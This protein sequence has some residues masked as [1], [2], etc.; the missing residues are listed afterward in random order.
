MDDLAEDGGVAGASRAAAS[1]TLLGFLGCLGIGFIAAVAWLNWGTRVRRLCQRNPMPL[2]P[3]GS[4]AHTKLV[5]RLK[6]VDQMHLVTEVVHHQ[7]GRVGLISPLFGSVVVLS[8]A[9]EAQKL[10]RDRKTWLVSKMLA[11]SI[12]HCMKNGLLI[13]D[14]EPWARHR[15]LLKPA[16]YPAHMEYVADATNDGCDVV[17]NNLWK[18][19]GEGAFD[20]CGGWS[21]LTVDVVGIVGFGVDFKSVENP[22]NAM[23]K[24]VRDVMRGAQLRTGMP[25]W[26][27][28]MLFDDNYDEAIAIQRQCIMKALHE[29]RQGESSAAKGGSAAAAGA[30]PRADILEVLLAGESGDALSTE[31][32]VDELCMMYVAGHETT[33]NTLMWTTL[34]LADNPDVLEELT[35]EVLAVVGPETRPTLAHTSSLKYTEALINEV[36]RLRP[37]APFVSRGAAHDTTVLGHP[38]GKETV[39]FFNFRS[40]HRDPVAFPDPMRFDPSRWLDPTGKRA[41]KASFFPFGDGP[42]SCIGRGFAL[43][44]LKVALARVAQHLHA[45]QC[46]LQLPGTDSMAGVEELMTITLKPARLSAELVPLSK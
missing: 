26:A 46:R 12:G 31:E 14:G 43:V 41:S 2:L 6:K 44:E 21:A 18:G 16:F 23:A 7:L 29:R 25:K 42:K 35:K 1:V 34:Y 9:A 19:P 37:V 4:F 5:R 10:L 36:L 3:G 24:A 22:D 20:V 28:G 11:T 32:V 17:L 40:M 38:V 15:R 30:R 13:I 8:D 39:V 33:A 27:W 45:A